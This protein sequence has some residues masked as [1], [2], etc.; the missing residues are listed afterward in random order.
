MLNRR[1]F[2]LAGSVAGGGVALGLG[3]LSTVDTR[4]MDPILSGDGKVALNAWIHIRSDGKIVFAIPR[5]EMGQGVFTSLPALIAEELD[6]ELDDP[7]LVIEHPTE[8]LPA[9]SNFTVA[10]YKRPEE[11]DGPLDW[12][13]RK[14][15]GLFPYIGTGGSTSVVD[16]YESFRRA[17]ASAREMLKQA[18]AARWNTNAGSLS[19]AGGYVI[20]SASNERL[21]YADL[22]TDAA[23]QTPPAVLEL[24][25]RNEWRQIGK[26]IPRTDLTAKVTGEPIFGIDVERDNMLYAH[27]QHTPVLGDTIDEFN[28]EEI[29][30]L[31][32]VNSVVNLGNAVVVVAETYF[33]AK[34]AAAELKIAYVDGGFREFSDADVDAALE[35]GFESG[36]THV[37]EQLGDVSSLDNND[38]VI[39]ANYGT[40]YLAHACMEPMNATALYQDG[41][42]KIWAPVQSP[43]SLK[44]A[45]EK[46]IEDLNEFEGHVT[47]LGGGFGRRA[48]MDYTFQAVQIA[49]ENPGRAVKLI[50]SREEDIQ[51]DMYRPAAKARFQATMGEDGLPAA[52]D[53]HVSLQSVMLSFSRRALP[54]PQGGANDPLN[55]EGIAHSSYRIPNIKVTAH[56]V[57]LPVPVGNW[58]S[59]GHSNNAFFMESFID[60][61]AHAAGQDPLTYRGALLAHDERASR[62][63]AQLKELSAWGAPMDEAAP[64][65]QSGKF[66]RGI[67]VHG[68]FLSLVG[69]VV[70]VWVTEDTV[71]VEKVFCVV[72]CGT[73]I[74]PDTIVAQMEGGIIYA[75]SAVA[76][77]E[78]N[79]EGGKVRQSNFHD[80]DVVRMAQCPAI[81]VHIMKNEELPGGVG[82]P[83]TPP[84]FPAVTN[85]IFAANGQRIRELPLSKH[86]L[87]LV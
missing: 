42:V 45:A 40:P 64:A 77:G 22:A 7:E 14:V 21:K 4:G 37:A 43:L 70:D 5:A 31:P 62:L 36:D 23:E 33:H 3:Y 76:Q 38:R 44:W 15:F 9:Y 71:K 29:L 19:T 18:A 2:L 53:A 67:A 8:L 79:F 35:Q 10:T 1:A 74:N 80:Q 78:I 59:V 34:R 82:E 84:L 68:S 58:R 25:P 6:I 66:G 41:R 32:R 17:G 56:D 69:Q 73:A 28:A 86:G 63:I 26:S 87:R 13:M 20:N 72:D 39:S 61:L 55:T 85:A 81:D 47:Y 65:N 30:A 52:L 12:T 16:S 54:F 24:K 46:N 60:E 57:D 75:L 51:H 50:W 48:E 27:I 83:G 49:R 11:H